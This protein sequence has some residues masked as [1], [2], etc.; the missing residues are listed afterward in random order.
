M[1]KLFTDLSILESHVEGLVERIR[2]NDAKL[3]HI[4]AIE[5]KL[6]GLNSLAELVEFVLEDAGKMF[7]LEVV[8]FC[9][10]DEREE[11]C[12]YLREGGLAAEKTAGLI[13]DGSDSRLK[14]LF[15][16]F[17]RPQLDHYC[18][19]KY[20]FFFGSAK[21]ISSIAIIPLTRRGKYLGSIN[22]G[23]GEPGRFEPE[24]ATDFLEHLAA[25]L[26][27]CVENAMNFELLRK[28]SLVD[29]LTGVNN[30]RFLEQRL[31]EEIVRMRRSGDPLSCLFVDIDFFKSVNDNHGH[32]TG[33]QVL[34]EVA[35]VMR[36]QLR[37]TDVLAR[38]GGEEFVAL[39]S[40][41][42]ESQA[43]SIAERIRSRVA[44][45]VV[46]KDDGAPI[47]VTVSIGL[48]TLLPEAGGQ[49]QGS[50]K[51]LISRSDQALYEAKRSGRNRVVSAGTIYLS[52]KAPSISRAG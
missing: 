11:I 17:P 31:D 41:S 51:D 1:D 47:H 24:M 44:E 34:A 9:L 13:L 36:A 38:Y 8:S 12:G 2:R 5:S 39:L 21:A 16:N 33:D 30:R 42:D 4:H 14:Q 7:G 43:I 29:T 3:R 15:G 19:E 20:A 46:L 32:Q 22:L 50:E 40:G 45:R 49:T 6:L 18:A 10:V 28:T 48:A 27:V 23:S 37:T 26:G 25:V 52:R 35:R